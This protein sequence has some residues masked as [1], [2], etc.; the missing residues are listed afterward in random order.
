MLEGILLSSVTLGAGVLALTWGLPIPGGLMILLG[1]L[2]LELTWRCRYLLPLDPILK[3]DIDEWM[4]L[5]TV[6]A[7]AAEERWHRMFA[8]A[9]T[10][11]KHKLAQ[12]R[13]QALLDRRAA[14]ELRNRLR[15]K[16]FVGKGVRRWVERSMG[17]TPEGSAVLQALD[18]EASHTRQ[19]WHE[20]EEFL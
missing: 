9:R 19:R 16:L 14:V 11:E 20:A 17:S 12:L 18:R 3:E 2:V 15:E 5:R 4:S 10:R 6:D 13:S 7:A 8:E 1:G